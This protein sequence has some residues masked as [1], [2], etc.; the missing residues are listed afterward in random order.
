MTGF[1][2]MSP[3]ETDSLSGKKKEKNSTIETSLV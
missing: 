1:T 3:V 2:R